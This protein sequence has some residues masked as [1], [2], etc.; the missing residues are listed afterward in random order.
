MRGVAERRAHRHQPVD[1]TVVV[2]AEHDEAAVEPAA[3][4]V[5]V[6]GEVTGQVG[7]LAVGLDDHPVLV[8][9]ELLGGQPQGAVLLVGVA[10]LGES[11]DRLPHRTAGVQV[12]LVEVDVEVDAEVVQALLDLGEHQLDADRPGRPPGPRRRAGRARRAAGRGR[13]WRSRRCSRRRSRPRAPAGPAQPR[14]SEPAEPVDLAAV[15]VE[16]VLP[17]DLGAG[18]RDDPAERVADGGPADAADV[19][20]PGRVGGDELE[21]DL[22]AREGVGGAVR[23]TGG[24]ESA[25]TWPWAPAST[26]MLRN[27]GPATSTVAMPSAVREPRRRA[28]RRAPAGCCPA[29]LASCI[30]TLVA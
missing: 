24:D 20:R 5:E 28:G 14:S 12:V 25:A 27:P 11:R 23:R 19:D 10:E 29:F 13:P 30:A 22:L 6:V 21:V 26:V 17:G 3:A 1:V 15:V 4:L 8:V 16:V 7:A 18:H 2:G 9:T